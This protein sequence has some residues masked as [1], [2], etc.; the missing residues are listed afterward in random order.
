MRKLFLI[1]SFNLGFTAAFAGENDDWLIKQCTLISDV[2]WRLKT[3]TFGPAGLTDNFDQL[4]KDGLV[5]IHI[6]YVKDTLTY[7]YKK[8]PPSLYKLFYRDESRSLGTWEMI[9]KS[10]GGYVDPTNEAVLRFTD[11]FCERSTKESQIIRT[12]ASEHSFSHRIFNCPC[13]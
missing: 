7:S 11:P 12:Y 1:I 4:T 6:N 5:S 13:E 8:G 3:T 10:Y 2:S 9:F